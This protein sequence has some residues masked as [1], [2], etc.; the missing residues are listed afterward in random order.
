MGGMAAQIPITR[1]PVANAAAMEKVRAD[2]L[3]EVLAGHD[4]TWVAHPG[5]I[6]L[7]EEIFDSKMPTPNQLQVRRA[8]VQVSRDQLIAPATGSI[9]RAGFLNNIDVCVRYVAAWLDGLGCVPIHH[10]MEDAATAE[11]SRSQLWQW[12]HVGGLSLDDGTPLD[13]Q[14]FDQA[15]ATIADRVDLQGQIG[16]RQFA[17]AVALLGDWT[18]AEDLIEFLT[19]PSYQRLP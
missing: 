9:T 2:K 5:L 4:G 11:I 15:L 17:E 6:A 13:F 7:A 10:L 12:L 18:H 8:D 14:L 1:D 16:A 3:R 19:L